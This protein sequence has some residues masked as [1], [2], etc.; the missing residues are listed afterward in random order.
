MGLGSAYRQAFAYL[1]ENEKPEFI[2]ELDADLSHDPAQIPQ[3][4][5][6]MKRGYDLVTGARY[7]P[8]GSTP[9]WNVFRKGIS[10]TAN[11]YTRLMLGWTLH[12]Y[13]TGYRCYRA[14]TLAKIDLGA[15]KSEGYS[16]Q[17][18]MSFTYLQ[19]G[20][21]VG[22]VPIRFIDRSYGH[23]KFSKKIV[24]EAVIRVLFFAARRLKNL[25]RSPR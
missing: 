18:E 4:L 15:I 1:L 16:F 14:D 7:V 22:E 10:W 20:F 21:R 13:T 12:D 2:F 24:L 9:T 6:K 5:E 3:F 11:L 17:V 25:F 19:K 8:G 23:S